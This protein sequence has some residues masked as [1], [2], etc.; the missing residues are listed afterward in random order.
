MSEQDANNAID[1]SSSDDEDDGKL[2]D[3]QVKT[4][5]ASGR[6][7]VDYASNI[8]FSLYLCMY[9]LQAVDKVN[10]KSSVWMHFFEIVKKNGKPRGNK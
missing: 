5:L 6:L 1:I 3:G 4:K 10:P 9:S 2:S 7:K 8:I